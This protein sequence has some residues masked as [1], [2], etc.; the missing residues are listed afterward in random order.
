M[1]ERSSDVMCECGIL[2]PG[3][4]ILQDHFIPARCRFHFVCLILRFGFEFKL[5]TLTLF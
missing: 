4:W 2:S 5:F 1:T 3:Y